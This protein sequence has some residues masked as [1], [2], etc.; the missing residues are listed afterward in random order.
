MPGASEPAATPTRFVGRPLAAYFLV[1]HGIPHEVA[2]SAVSDR[3]TTSSSSPVAEL[4]EALKPLAERYVRFIPT[5]LHVFKERG[6]PKFGFTQLTAAIVP[7]N[8]LAEEDVAAQS[9][10][11]PEVLTAAL[12][13]YVAFLQ[14]QPSSPMRVVHCT[15]DTLGALDQTLLVQKAADKLKALCLLG[16]KVEVGPSITVRRDGF[17]V[18]EL[19]L[20]RQLH[21]ATFP[22]P[23]SSDDITA[24]IGQQLAGS[25]VTLV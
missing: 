10:P 13:E 18:G 14:Q 21:P 17:G 22:E 25:R 7:G 1:L 3:L 6:V 4:P 24:F 2:L 5:K 11:E 9:A 12:G 20:L 16:S 23:A 15:A 19:A 8:G